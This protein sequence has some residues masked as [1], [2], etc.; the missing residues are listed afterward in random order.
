MAIEKIATNYLGSGYDLCGKYADG[1]SV[2]RKIFD[3]NKV[4]GHAVRQLSNREAQFFSVSGDSVEEYQS[5]LAVKAGVSGSYGLFSASVEASFN[6][7]DRS[8]SE[9]SFVSI[10]LCMR[11]ETWKLQVTSQEYM[12]PDVVEKFNTR[13]GKWLIE[14]FGA[15]VVVGMDVGGRWSDNFS[16][17]K[18]Y[19]NSTMDVTVSMEAAYGSFVS[20]KGSVEVSNAVD[21]KES[22]ANRRV[23]LVGG[24]PAFAPANLE[25]WQKSVEETPAFMNFTE[26]GLAMIWDL[27]PEHSEKLK[28]G[29]DEYIKGKQLDSNKKRIVE[30][31]YVEGRKYADN[32]GFV[33]RHHISLYKP[34]ISE[35]YKFIGVSGHGNK[36]LVV[37]AISDRYGALR[38]PESWQRVWYCRSSE[39]KKFYSCWM[40]RVPPG[41]VALGVYCRFGADNYDP[42][43][44][45]EVNGMV[46]VHKSLT[47][48]CSYNNE[49][50]IW[51]NAETRSSGQYEFTLA[52]LPSMAVWPAHTTDPSMGDMPRPYKLKDEFLTDI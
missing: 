31:M 32:L 28:K 24:D 47:E 7:T 15:G 25:D 36:A 3:L 10:N 37:R 26:D 38:E 1:V 33:K 17:S 6:K 40:P 14:Q 18:L 21:S 52:R 23:T 49:P 43:T 50:D 29:F 41:F 13:D 19:N 20:G 5:K 48:E 45:E 12:Y 2:K 27:F 8:I 11:Y 46:V 44:K 9:S 16:V 30:T 4:P 39:N 51:N 22:I 35:D 42:P 34:D